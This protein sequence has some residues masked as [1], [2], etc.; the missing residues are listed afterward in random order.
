M[1]QHLERHSPS[2]LRGRTPVRAV[3]TKRKAVLA[4]KQ[5]RKLGSPVSE[6][7]ILERPEHLRS[8]L[9]RD[10]EAGP[11]RCTC[12]RARQLGT[13]G[14]PQLLGRLV[15]ASYWQDLH[16]VCMYLRRYLHTYA[17]TYAYVHV[18]QA[19]G[20]GNQTRPLVLL[21]SV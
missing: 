15:K 1:V 9:V 13:P 10:S 21:V 17:C 20:E 8:S 4:S 5:D 6:R 14:Q 11:A 3:A 7:W 18:F 2:L 19:A 16:G 12:V